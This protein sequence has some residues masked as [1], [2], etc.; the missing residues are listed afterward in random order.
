MPSQDQVA[1]TQRI[2]A[3]LVGLSHDMLMHAQRAEWVALAET[4]KKR[5]RFLTE[6]AESFVH[7]PAESV[8]LEMWSYLEA[9]QTEMKQILTEHSQE[10]LFQSI[11]LAKPQR[12]KARS[13]SIQSVLRQI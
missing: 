5:V 6:F 4:A 7:N 10:A 3:M 8:C 11:A 2:T 13:W 9:L 1:Q 12:A